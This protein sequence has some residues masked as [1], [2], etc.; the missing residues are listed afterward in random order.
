MQQPHDAVVPGQA[1]AH[2]EDAHAADEGGDVAHVGETV[3]GG[4][5]AGKVSIRDVT[6]IFFLPDT[7]SAD[8]LLWQCY[9]SGSRSVPSDSEPLKTHFNHS[10]I[11]Y[12]I[13]S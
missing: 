12:F 10:S 11:H 3:A 6:V 7:T 5:K 1:G 8:P 2:H 13:H 9:S 4:E